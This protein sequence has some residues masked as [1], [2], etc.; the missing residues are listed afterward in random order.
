MRLAA[1]N[2]KA[3]F[4]AREVA[5]ATAVTAILIAPWLTPVDAVSWMS[6]GAL[7][8]FSLVFPRSLLLAVPLTVGFSFKPFEAGGLQ[9]NLLEVLITAALLGYL[10]RAGHWLWRNAGWARDNPASFSARVMPDRLGGG[11]ALVLFLAG[12]VSLFTLA[13]PDHLQE[14]LRTFRWTILFPVAYF[15]LAAPMVRGEELRQVA[16][17]LFLAGACA[18]AVIAV[19]DGLSGGGVQADSVTR[20]AGLAPHPNA[21]AL[22][23]ERAAV[24]GLLIGVLHRERNGT[25]WAGGAVLMTVVTL[26]TFS[27][28]GALAI[29]VGCLLM[30]LLMRARIYAA[31][32]ALV[33]AGI[34]AGLAMLVPDRALSF[35]SGGSGSLRLELWRSSIEMIRDHP[36]RGVGLDQF[37]YQY[38]PRYVSPEAWPE[39]FTS[40]PHNVLLDA[41]L[42]LGI[43]GPV[44][45]LLLGVLWVHRVRAALLTR[46]TISL[47][48]AGA[49]VGGLVHGLLDQSYFLPELAVSTWLLIILLRPASTA[50]DSPPDTS[51]QAKG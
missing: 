44:I 32:A 5:L 3:R 31:V 6:L 1:G 30:L 13:D 23:L 8:A 45:L 17:A 35:M 47:A 28:G 33:G 4:I 19:A 37:L 15:F 48:A 10:P 39:R 7:F 51:S 18:T 24:L 26:L 34:V 40:H 2:P 12:A 46:D 21:L 36:L 43:I 38:L 29:L 9:L 11:I 25:W 49:L 41:W 50:E 42:S 14:S 16:A 22:V 27:R 20:L